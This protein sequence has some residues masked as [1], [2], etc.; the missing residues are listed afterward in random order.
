MKNRK[1]TGGII[2]IVLGIIFFLKN[3]INIPGIEI[4]WNYI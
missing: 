2:L 4:D 1:C 3:F